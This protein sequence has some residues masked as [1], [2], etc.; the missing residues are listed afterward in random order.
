MGTIRK[1]VDAKKLYNVGVDNALVGD[2]ATEYSVSEDGL[3]WTFQLR[4]DVLFHDGMP[5]TA[6][7][8]AFTYNHTKS[9][10]SVLDLSNMK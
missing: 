3:M 2:L 1:C 5:L 4:E 7:D 10:P 6:K 8:V 9:L